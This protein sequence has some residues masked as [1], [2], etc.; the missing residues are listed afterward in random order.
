MKFLL[1]YVG[2]IPKTK[3]ISDP[4]SIKYILSVVKNNGVIGIFAE[5]RRN[6]DGS[7]LPLVRPTAK[8]VKSLKIPVVSVLFKGAYLT[9][10]RWAKGTRRGELT[11]ACSLV[12][13]GDDVAKRSVDEIYDAMTASLA[14]DEYE[15]QRRRMIPYRGGKK[16]ESLELFLFR[17]PECG[18]D[19]HM[20]SRGDR[21]FCENC[22][23]AVI[24]DEY[25]FFKPAADKLYFDN[26][27]DWNLWQLEALEKSLREDGVPASDAPRLEDTGVTGYKGGK[28]G[29]LTKQTSCGVLR[30]Y[31]DRLVFAYGEN[32][33]SFAVK[34]ISGENIQFNYAFE[35][36]HEKAVYRFTGGS[37]VISAYKWVKA[38]EILKGGENDV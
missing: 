9:M 4:K 27:R 26:P 31:R 30:L 21:F 20:K 35:F 6:W 5:G 25:G 18:S 7:T 19:N 15:W 29:S 3:F 22:N 33:Q 16:A 23:Y 2:A 12:L 37:G 10:P 28:E 32:T 1:K 11:M 24:Y 38:L 34:D 14:H 36:R 8:L 17:C 13:S